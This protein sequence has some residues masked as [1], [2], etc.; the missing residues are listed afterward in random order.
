MSFTVPNA[1]DPNIVSLDQA[2]PDSLDFQVLGRGRTG[3]LSGGVVTA[4]SGSLPVTA[5]EVSING[6][7]GNV[8]NGS[9]AVS[10]ADGSNPRFD[11]V[12]VRRSGSS[13][14]LTVIAG[15]SNATNP[16][17]PS[18]NHD[19]DLLLAALYRGPGTEFAVP[20]EAIVD[21]RVIL[22]SGFTRSGPG[23]PAMS[24]STGDGYVQTTGSSPLWIN[25]NGSWVNIAVDPSAVMPVG[26]VL[27]W[28]GYAADGPNSSYWMECDGRTLSRSAYTTL[29]NVIG[30]NFGAAD[31]TTFRIPDYR[32][33][34]PRGT[35]QAGQA[36]GQVGGANSVTLTANNIPQLSH[37]TTT[38]G[39]TTSSGGV[40]TSEHTIPSQSHM[41]SYND[42]DHYH[43]FPHT[44]DKGLFAIPNTS[45]GGRGSY[46][47]IE[48]ATPR[49]GPD[50]FALHVGIQGT[51]YG[52]QD[53]V[54]DPPTDSP[55]AMYNYTIPQAAGGLNGGDQ[56]TTYAVTGTYTSNPFMDY[57]PDPT[58][59][60]KS[61]SKD[62]RHFVEP[63]PEIKHSHT[64]PSHAH[65]LSIA[66]HGSATPTA[67]DTVP[68][69]QTT[70]FF[71]K[72]L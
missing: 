38:T 35:P 12:V 50:M 17:F 65:A 30:S 23:S 63:H 31:N 55:E 62:H 44:H 70:R 37:T 21:K 15:S 58:R 4:G 52:V 26:T 34:V 67:V 59:I 25:V 66:A 18:I 40:I 53:A 29:F 2:E 51:G 33:R 9:V 32:N 3:V 64:V 48:P 72:Y 19:T 69:H 61:S 16:R 46:Y 45:D 68:A 13:F 8:G 22:P 54:D 56:P 24:A 27:T 20:V 7:Y 28:A 36:P 60:T 41:V 5:A 1:P 57:P 39:G 71:I 49:P 47:R 6:V 10:A 42:T 43:F 11:L 14:S